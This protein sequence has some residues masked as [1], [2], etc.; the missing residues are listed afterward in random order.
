MFFNMNI[1]LATYK[2]ACSG[3]FISL[4]VPSR[5]TLTCINRS[6]ANI[7]PDADLFVD[8]KRCFSIRKSWEYAVA[9]IIKYYFP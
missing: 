9:T 7:S 2:H 8:K 1:Y 3:S 6:Q 5:T 4:A